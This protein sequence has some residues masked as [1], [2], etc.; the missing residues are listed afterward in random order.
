[1]K[2]DPAKLK[3]DVAKIKRNIDLTRHNMEAAN[4]MIGRAE[5]PTTKEEL[6]AE[7]KRRSEAL[8]GMGNGIKEK[9]S[10]KK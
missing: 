6:R 10:T 5:S 4:E 8:K 9:G 3:G 7:N 1:M 2:I